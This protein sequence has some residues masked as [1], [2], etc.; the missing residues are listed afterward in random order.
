MDLTTITPDHQHGCKTELDDVV[1]PFVKAGT[2]FRYH[3]Y[4]VP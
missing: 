2:E 1:I 3:F 4:I